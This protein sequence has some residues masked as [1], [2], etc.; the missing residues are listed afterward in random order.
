[1]L[2]SRATAMSCYP[3]FTMTDDNTI[4]METNNYED[5]LRAIQFVLE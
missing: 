1:M 5:I 3:G 4:R 2:F